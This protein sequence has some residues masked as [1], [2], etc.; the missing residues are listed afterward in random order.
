MLSFVAIVA[1]F[2][3]LA[4]AAAVQAVTA[5]GFALL[6]VPLLA[7]T[8]D[9]PT[10]VV[11]VGVAGVLMNFATV[12]IDR[13]HIRW[14]PVVGLLAAATVGMPFGL[15][16]LR[17]LSER[18]LGVLVAAAVLGC[19]LIVWLRPTLRGGWLAVASAGVFAGVLA[20][21]TGTNGPP[22]VAVFLGMGFT[23][24]EVRASLAGYFSVSGVLSV[25]AFATAGELTRPVWLIGAVGLVA[26]PL[27]WWLGNRLF[28][29][30]DPLRFRRAVLA[31]L[32]LT[33]VMTVTRALIW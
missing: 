20:T 9:V 8:D 1:I 17:G 29:R 19:A 13:A 27:G 3:I 21:A 14:R 4:T 32:V 11:G 26:V 31:M 12:R 7:Q 15:L 33:S 2:A 5:F 24:A 23:P 16:L 10:A 30:F 22:L 6:A 28:R 25:V 18:A